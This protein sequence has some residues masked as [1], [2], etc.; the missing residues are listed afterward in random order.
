[1]TPADSVVQRQDAILSL[2]KQGPL[3][4][5]RI[6]DVTT[7][8]SGPYCTQILGDLGAEVIKVE[9]P[10]GDATRTLPPHF[11][12]GDSTYFLSTNRNKKSI[13][14]DL[15]VDEGKM[16]FRDLVRR[17][18]VLVENFRPGVLERLGLTYDDMA[19]ESP[20]L[21]WCSISGFGQ[22]GPNR[23]FPAYDMMIQALSGVMSLTGERGGLPV[24]TGIPLSDLAAG[25]FA[26][27]GILAAIEERSSSGQG[28]QIDI[29][30]LDSQI[31]MLSYLG[32]YHLVSGD[33]PSRQGR[34]H[35]SIPTYRSFEGRD[36][37]QLVITANTEAMWR[38][39]CE[40]LE[41]QELVHDDRFANNELRNL[42][43][44][45]LWAILGQRFKER[46]AQEWADDLL[47][48][49]VPTATIKNL[50]EALR[51]PQVVHRN[52]VVELRSPTGT[53]LRLLGDPVKL[54]RTRRS[55]HKYPPK[56]GE[57]TTSVLKELLG[58]S[59]IRIEELREAGAIASQPSDGRADP[60]H[61]GNGEH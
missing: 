10:A 28:Q 48:A 59:E 19:K 7:F 55:S 34:G 51:D 2:D 52:M 47:A 38:S 18:D 58:L 35:E 42:N 15:K 9:H 39:L 26:V 5:L 12:E 1:M 46:P 11:V 8:L 14:I 20:G 3:S 60:K 36:G 37:E 54:S 56:L 22:D 44:E 23:D 17:C 30:L 40:V 61:S 32:T 53:P 6:L 29:S 50:D 43:R 33:V 49:S 4:N 45:P 13:V 57:D 41:L 25:M 16:L 27:I 21:V 24:R 31:S